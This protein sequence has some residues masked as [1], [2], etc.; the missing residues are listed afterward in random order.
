MSEAEK[1]EVKLTTKDLRTVYNTWYFSTEL[2]NS[3]DRLQGLAFCNALKK[4]LRKIYADDDAAY[5]DALVRHMEF[6]NSEGTVGCMIHGIVLSMEEQ[7]ANGI[8][9]PGEVITGIKTGLM[10]PIA[11]IGD[12]IIWG[13][14]KAIILGLGCTFSLQ[15][16]SLGAVIPFLFPIIGYTAGWMFL[17]FGYR[18]GKDAV[19]K[20]MQSGVINTVITGA[21][22][23]GLFMMGALSSSYVKVSTPLQFT[24][25]NA[26]PIIIQD[27]LD[28]LLLGI[29]PLCSIFG[30]YWYFTH[31]EA[32][33]NKVILFVLLISMVASFFGI[34]G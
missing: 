27:I 19:L 16:N 3:Y 21:S 11:G 10:G 31:K 6:Y 15:G 33:Y 17:R 7:N 9:V 18:L 30:I 29:L 25:E 22:V 4:A 13:T 1:K 12:T 14:L 34:L 23:L 20:L 2:S 24:M 32:N 26:S 5:K 28:Q 8:P